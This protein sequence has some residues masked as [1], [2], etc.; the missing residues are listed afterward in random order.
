[1]VKYLNGALAGFRAVRTNTRTSFHAV[2]VGGHPWIRAICGAGPGVRSAGWAVEEDEITCP[3]CLQLMGTMAGAGDRL[4]T[5][6][7][8][9][10]APK[11]S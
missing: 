4:T 8:L 6:P 5:T 10:Y 9:Q 2:P 7:G 1:M 11:L 3:R